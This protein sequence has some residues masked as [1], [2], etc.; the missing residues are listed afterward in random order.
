MTLVV[1]ALSALTVF[2]GRLYMEWADTLTGRET[3]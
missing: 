3:E 2:L 1:V